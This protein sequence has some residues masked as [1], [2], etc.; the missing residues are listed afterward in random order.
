MQRKL[1]QV[2]VIENQL[3]NIAAKD[4]GAKR[5]ICLW[6]LPLLNSVSAYLSELHPC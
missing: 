4:F 1:L 3:L 5:E 2:G 6:S